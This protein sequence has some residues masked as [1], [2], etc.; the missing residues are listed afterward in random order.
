MTNTTKETKPTEKKLN[1]T[2]QKVVDFLNVHKGEAFTLEEIAKG[3]GVEMKSSG[4]I[5]RLLNSAKNPDG[6]IVH[7]EEK[8]RVVQVKRKVSTYMI[9]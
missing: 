1:A 4:A 2:A 8:E 6:I 5:T 7:G 3:I 9:K